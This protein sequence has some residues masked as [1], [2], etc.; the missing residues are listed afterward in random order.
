MLALSRRNALRWAGAAVATA[1]TLSG[2]TGSVAGGA[3]AVAGGTEAVA[4]RHPRWARLRSRLSGTLLLPD[5]PGYDTARLP[6]N[7]LFDHHRPAAIARCTRPEDVQHCLEEARH[8]DLPVAARSGGHSYAAYS[9]PHQGLVIDLAPMSGVEVRPDGTA[10]VGAGA[11][12]RDVYTALAAAGRCLPLGN[13]PSVGIAGFTLGGGLG[14]LDRTY[15]LTCDWLRS[16]RVV[17]VDSRRLTTSA[18]HAPDLF[19]ALRGGGGGNFGVVTGFEFATVPAPEVLTVFRVRFPA[20][21]AAD[22]LG[23]WQPWSVTVPPELSSVCVVTPTGAVDLTGCAIGPAAL[24]EAEI[25]RLLTAVGINAPLEHG[26]VDYPTAITIMTGG[27]PPRNAFRASSR[28]AKGRWEDATPIV[29]TLRDK[30]SALLIV[31]ALGGAIDHPS[32]TD[33]AYPHRGAPTSVEVFANVG[34][35][36]PEQVTREVD[37]VQT[38][39]ANLVGTGTY[40]NYLDPLQEDWA[41]T[42]YE[43]NLPRLRAVARRYDPDGVLHFPQSIR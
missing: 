10:V 29:N 2:G 40:I 3:E 13:C 28:I 6:F 21:S 16:A 23:A 7:S 19:W 30:E 4:G 32:P 35:L 34:T 24:L 15:G 18:D 8:S 11:R 33:T 9:T 1:A 17:T 12:L 14:W 43:H 27:H 25:T 39:L 36:P 42:A 37:D 31:G 22:V 20:G 26:E 5:D 38:T 41:T